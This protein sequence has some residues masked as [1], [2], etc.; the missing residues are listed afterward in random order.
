MCN[1]SCEKFQ[2]KAHNCLAYAFGLWGK[3]VVK[4]HF[5]VLAGSLSGFIY[6]TM[7]YLDLPP[8]AF[9]YEVWM[10]SV[11]ISFFNTPVI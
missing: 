1:D 9:V 5:L 4:L 3:I 7:N 11:S 8:P 10:P 2:D 6:A